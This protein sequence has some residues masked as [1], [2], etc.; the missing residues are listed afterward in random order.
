MSLAFPHRENFLAKEERWLVGGAA[1]PATAGTPAWCHG[2]C[3]RENKLLT[4][5]TLQR[6]TSAKTRATATRRQ[7]HI[8][9]NV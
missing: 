5:I 6:T 8:P 4:I 2:F 9:P 3:Q 7:Q 1:C